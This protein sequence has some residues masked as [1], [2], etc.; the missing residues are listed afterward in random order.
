V[1][2]QGSPAPT[3]TITPELVAAVAAAIGQQRPAE[4][5]APN[6]YRLGGPPASNVINLDEQLASIDTSAQKVLLD[7]HTYTVRRDLTPRE[8]GQWAKLAEAGEELKCWAMLVGEA[9]AQRLNDY[10]ET[11][12]TLK[13]NRVVAQLA[14]IAGV[15][16]QTGA[17]GEA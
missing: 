13:S 12:P 11:L 7:G 8:A 14:V 1:N 9:D 3:P 17:Q 10:T 5:P 4:P 16:T 15:A 6:G 2:E